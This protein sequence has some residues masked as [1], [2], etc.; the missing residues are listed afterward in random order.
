MKKKEKFL[1]FCSELLI[2]SSLNNLTIHKDIACLFCYTLG[3]LDAVE[4]ERKKRKQTCS[5]ELRSDTRRT[6][7]CSRSWSLR[8]PRRP[9]V[10]PC[11]SHRTPSSIPDALE[12][13]ASISQFLLLGT[14]M[15]E[16]RVFLRVTKYKYTKIWMYHVFIKILVDYFE[17]L[18]FWQIWNNTWLG[19]L[20][21]LTFNQ[22]SAIPSVQK[23]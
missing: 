17:K 2:L 18:K 7:R 22:T 12:V 21:L 20:F 16:L 4:V 11:H 13:V 14:E 6:G 8:V 1:Y 10:A 9:T 3:V 19:R 23:K 15:P 5:S